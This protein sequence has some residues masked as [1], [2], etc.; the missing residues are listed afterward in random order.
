MLIISVLF[1]L[2]DVISLE[3]CSSS[4]DKFSWPCLSENAFIFSFP[5]FKGLLAWYRITGW[6]SVW[7]P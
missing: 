3:Y 7:A 4:S 5:F 2:A 1:K 6:L